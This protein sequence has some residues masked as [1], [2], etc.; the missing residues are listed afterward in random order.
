MQ[1]GKI[2]ISENGVVSVPDNVMMQDFEIAELFG[3]FSQTIR[4][5]IQAILKSGLCEGDLSN[6]GTVIGN[7]I[8]SDYHG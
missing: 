1:Q 2:T 8:I 4:S 5:N 7:S 6:G 3:V